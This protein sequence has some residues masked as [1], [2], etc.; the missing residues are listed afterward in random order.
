M[1]RAEPPERGWIVGDRGARARRAARRQRAPLRGLDR[2]RAAVSLHPS[3]GVFAHSALDALVQSGRA[4]V[5]NEIAFAPADEATRSPRCSSPPADPVRLGAA[6]RALER[7]GVPWRFGSAMHGDAMAR[8]PTARARSRASRI[9]LRYSL[10]C[11]PERDRADTLAHR[12]GHAVDRRRPAL[13][14][15]RVSARAARHD[16]P[17]ACVVRAMAR[18]HALAAPERRGR[19]SARGRAWRARRAARGRRRTRAPAGRSD[20]ARRRHARRAVA[21]RH[22]LLSA[23]YHARGRARRES[24]S[25]PN[26]SS[27]VSRRRRSAIRSSARARRTC[28][29]DSTALSASVLTAAPQR[30]LVAPLLL[31]AAA[32]LLAETLITSAG[33]QEGA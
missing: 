3:A 4:C 20:D 32:L 26:R 23:R 30:P 31:I 33:T 22:V 8:A 27:T 1:L 28:F 18:R 29:T 21:R 5:G 15:H 7:L 25:R 24:P 6:N 9:D 17:A 16:L 13:R 14:A 2:P 11:A 12:G 19:H 10:T